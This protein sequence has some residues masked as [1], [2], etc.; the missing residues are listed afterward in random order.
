MDKTLFRKDFCCV[1]K[2]S[3][4]FVL[5]RFFSEKL[6]FAVKSSAEM[7]GGIDSLEEIRLRS[8][9]E[10]YITVGANGKKKN[11][12][13]GI[14]L[15]ADE[16]SDIFNEM[17]RGS[18]YAYSES[19][20]KGY[21]SLPNGIRVGVCGHASVEGGRIIGV[22]DVSALNIRIPGADISV[23]RS[24]LSLVR[25]NV[26]LGVGTLIFSPPSQGKTTCLR[27]LS[28]ELA[29]GAAPLRVSVVDTRGELSLTP[30]NQRLNLDML[31]G[32][33]KAEGIRIATLFM[34]PEVIACDEIG[35][36][37]EALSIVDAQNCG[38]PLIATAHGDSISS[39]MRKSGILALH[40]ACVFGS[41]ASIRIGAGGGFDIVTYSWE[42]AERAALDNRL[43]HSSA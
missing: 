42:E 37:E 10:I 9:R 16:L 41:Y 43:A 12:S 27:S 11:I 1:G 3:C 35:G 17:C 40:K 33:P 28:Y 24:L 23:N 7:N 14:S 31:T 20:A 4:F 38:V 13:V 8:Q 26:S 30:N 32:Y 21:I 34:N 39:L 6:Y 36:E 2:E 22:Y 29:S 15:S 18:L 19:I 5:R 25:K